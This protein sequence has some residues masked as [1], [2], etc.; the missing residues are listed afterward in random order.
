MDKYMLC[1]ASM[2]D[3]TAKS[4]H[5]TTIGRS[6]VDAISAYNKN[7]WGYGNWLRNNDTQTDNI[8]FYVV[9]NYINTNSQPNPYLLWYYKV[10][11]IV[12]QSQVAVDELKSSPM[13][14]VSTTPSHTH[15]STTT[16]SFW[17]PIV[18]DEWTKTLGAPPAWCMFKKEAHGGIPLAS[19]DTDTDIHWN[20]FWY[21]SKKL[22]RILPSDLTVLG[23]RAHVHRKYALADTADAEKPT[24]NV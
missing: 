13:D 8:S 11:T 19:A 2:H 23:I 20:I 12:N 18:I 5:Y 16:A 22:I 1:C 7:N 10:D 14:I 15:N 21:S 4:G 9:D 17:A 6:T 24:T 3:G